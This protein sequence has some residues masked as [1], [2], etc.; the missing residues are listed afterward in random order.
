MTKRVSYLIDFPINPPRMNESNVGKFLHREVCKLLSFSELAVRM[1]DF[2]SLRQAV[3]EFNDT[4][5]HANLV[6]LHADSEQ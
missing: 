2:G 6:T 4:G 3:I 5:N 1:T